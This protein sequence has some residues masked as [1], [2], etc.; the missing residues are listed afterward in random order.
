MASIR[1]RQ[2]PGSTP[3]IRSGMASHPMEV[4]ATKEISTAVGAQ[5]HWIGQSRRPSSLAVSLGFLS[6][7]SWE[8]ALCTIQ[9]REK[10]S[11]DFLQT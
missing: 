5:N 7:R 9:N 10:A 1:H 6:E 3:I 8:D 2:T 11:G 4:E